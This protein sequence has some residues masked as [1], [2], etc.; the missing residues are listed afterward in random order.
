[1]NFYI[2]TWLS[3]ADTVL[4]LLKG[5]FK[6]DQRH[7]PKKSIFLFVT[8]DKRL[9]ISHEILVILVLS[10]P[11]NKCS[12]KPENQETT[13]FSM[14]V[15]FHTS[16]S[17]ELHLHIVLAGEMYC[18]YSTLFKWQNPDCKLDQSRSR[19]VWFPQMYT[20]TPSSLSL[21]MGLFVS[22][23]VFVYHIFLLCILIQ[24]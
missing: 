20:T 6:F 8:V 15:T 19:T 17:V 14:L 5:S 1:M 16:F 21:K 11:F 10:A 24:K 13:E 18:F 4:P 7:T 9:W 12:C 22:P 2:V 23:R 3:N